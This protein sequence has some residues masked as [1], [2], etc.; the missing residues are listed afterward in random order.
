MSRIGDRYDSEGKPVICAAV[1]GE[2]DLMEENVEE[3]LKAYAKM[4]RCRGVRD[5]IMRHESEQI[6][7]ATEVLNKLSNPEFRRGF[8]LLEK[9]GLTFETWVR[10]RKH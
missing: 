7:R 2:A 9:Y 3:L 4:P 8:A 1:V 5:S 6:F 10:Q